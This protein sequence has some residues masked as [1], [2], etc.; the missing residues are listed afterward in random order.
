M[1]ILVDYANLETLEK[2]R[3]LAHVID[4]LVNRI[5]P[6]HLASNQGVHVRLYDGWYEGAVLSKQAQLIAAE[7]EAFSPSP[8]MVRHEGEH[9]PVRVNVELARSLISNPSKDILH[10]YRVRGFPSGLR[11]ESPPFDGCAAPD[12]C[13]WTLLPAFIT[14]RKCPK[15]GCELHPK[16]IIS[17]AEQKIVDTMLTS[18][19]IEICL[20]GERFAL[21]SSDDDMYPGISVALSRGSVVIHLQTK[22]GRT[23]SE[24][25]S[26]GL[27]NRY[28]QIEAR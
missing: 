6:D 5:G 17:R 2:N 13:L 8:V 24:H 19:M 21:V 12:S 18:D 28:I 22:P 15:D 26:D 9:F 7:I 23:L 10:T 4:S 25:Y 14:Q 20:R 27:P 1:W 11:S 3:G 16:K